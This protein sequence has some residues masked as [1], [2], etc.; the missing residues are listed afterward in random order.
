[1]N[2]GEEVKV[3][4]CGHWFDAGYVKAWLVQRSSTCPLCRALVEI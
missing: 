2:E 4:P 3:L 1:M